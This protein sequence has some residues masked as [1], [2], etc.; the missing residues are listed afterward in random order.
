LTGI[1]CGQSPLCSRD[2]LPTFGPSFIHLYGSTRDYSLINEHSSL[3]VGL[4]EVKANANEPKR[5]ECIGTLPMLNKEA[6]RPILVYTVNSRPAFP[7]EQSERRNISIFHYHNVYIVKDRDGGTSGPVGSRRVSYRARLLVSIR[8]EI[9]DNIDFMPAAVEVEPAVPVNEASYAKN[10]EFFLFA[11]IFE[12]SMIDKKEHYDSDSDELETVSSDSAS[13]QSTTTASKPMTH[14]KTYYFLPYWDNKPCMHIRSVWS[15]LRR[16]MYNSNIIAKVAEKLEE[17]LSEVSSLIEAD[18][19]DMELHLKQVLDELSVGCGKYTSISKASL[20]ELGPERQILFAQENIGI[21]ARNLRALVTKCSFKERYKTA[22]AYLNKLKFLTEDPQH[23]LPDVFLWIISGGKRQAYQRISARDI[24]YSLVEEERGRDCGK[25]QTMFLKVNQISNLICRVSEEWVPAAGRSPPSYRSTFWLGMLKHKKELH[26]RHPQGIRDNAGDQERGKA[27]GNASICYSLRRKALVEATFQLRA[28]IYQARSLIGSDASGLS[29]PF[30]RIVAGEF[31]KTTQVIDETLSPTWDELLIFDEIL[32]YGESEDIK[33][34]PPPIVIEIFDQDK[35]GKSEFI[36]RTLAKPIVK[37][38]DEAFTIT[39]GT[40][41]A[42]ELLAAFELLEHAISEVDGS[43]PSTSPKDIP[44][45]HETDTRQMG[46]LLP[47][48]KRIHLLTVDKPRVDIE[49]SGHILYSSIIQNY[50]KNPNCG[51]P[52]K[53]LDL[54][55][56]EQELYSAIQI[57]YTNQVMEVQDSTNKFKTEINKNRKQSLDDDAEDEE[58]SKDWWTKYFASVE[59]MIDE[60]KEAKRVYSHNGNLQVYTDDDNNPHSGNSSDKSPCQGEYK[61]RF[62]FKTAATASRFAAKI[63]PKKLQKAD[64]ILNLIFP[65]ELEAR[66]EFHEFK[67]WLHTSNCIEAR[68]LEKILRMKVGLLGI[69][70]DKDNYISKQLNPIFGKTAKLPLELDA[71]QASRTVTK[72]SLVHNFGWSKSSL[73]RA[74]VSYMFWLW[75]FEIEATFPQ[76]SLL[77]VQIFDWDLVGQT[78]WLERQ[79]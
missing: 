78:I 45:Y 76:D 8:T 29:D 52:V 71:D 6:S 39:R 56:P 25:V 1:K 4:G 28:H 20:A 13:W 3:N 23:A 59:R 70:S 10:E 14:D 18:A 37:L 11:T 34:E 66:P 50:K 27:T 36:G 35:V 43:L 9:T 74:L 47:D 7:P 62:G 55:L 68:K 65:T 17:G 61:R 79:N 41:H 5:E 22:Q 15:D 72:R 58:D 40:D 63:S 12:A 24:I 46:P 26:Q 64:L 67:E 19:P 77:T 2:F 57:N 31:S 51:T 33:R 48:L 32:I 38:K 69:L 75:C 73:S 21:A 49:C 53:F 60:S 44:I 42:G 30:A 16:R 54:D